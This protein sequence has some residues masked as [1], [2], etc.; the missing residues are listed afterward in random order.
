MKTKF[1]IIFVFMGSLILFAVIM[2]AGSYTNSAHGSNSSG[3]CRSYLYQN[4]YSKGNCSH[5]HEQHASINGSEPEPVNGQPS[6]FC[7]FADN[8]NSSKTV[9][10]YDQSDDFC[11]YCHVNLNSLQCGGGITNYL[12]SNTAGGYSSY[13]ASDI[14]GAFN[15]QSY[16]NLYDIQQFA[17]SKFAF[18]KNSSNPCVACHN[19]HIAT[20]ETPISRPTDHDNLWGDDS[21]ERMNKYLYYRAPYYY[22][23]TTTYEPGGT[24]INDGSLTPDY[25][26]FCLDCHQYQVPTTQSSSRN[27]NTPSGYLTA[28]DWSSSGDMH[29]ERARLFKIDGSDNPIRRSN[30]SLPPGSIIAPYNVSPVMDNYV[31]SCLDC[32]E[33]HGTFFKS[34]YLLRREVNGKVVQYTGPPGSEVVNQESFCTSCHTFNH[35]GGPLGCFNCH[36]HGAQNRGCAGPWNGPNF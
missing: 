11:F 32:H 33:P 7:L 2:K 24:T 9:G 15:L 20:K 25:N 10:P 12:Y 14:L 3:V 16:H 27:P 4:G 29:G 18:F 8:F 31:L 22:G 21:N 23:S 19:P 17:K 28:I 1:R 6:G 13:D 35:C 5:C 30:P 34:S 26:S 36:Y